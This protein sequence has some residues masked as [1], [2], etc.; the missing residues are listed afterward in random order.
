MTPKEQF[1]E[2][3]AELRSKGKLV[4]K[5]VIHDGEEEP[6][7]TLRVKGQR[8]LVEEITA[9]EGVTI[10]RHT[11]TISKKR[12]ENLIWANLPPIQSS[13]EENPGA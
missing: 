10:S 12:A 13:K 3:L 11:H 1:N 7:L 8:W 9:V 6:S 5:T 2:L 4:L